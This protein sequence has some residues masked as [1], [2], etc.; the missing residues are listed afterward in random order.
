MLDQHHGEFSTGID[1]A[2]RSRYYI[3]L[4]MGDPGLRRRVGQA[5]RERALME[6][7]PE[8]FRQQVPLCVGAT[9][10]RCPRRKSP[11]VPSPAG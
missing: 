2:E 5:A 6:F 3:H 11:A 10:I 9:I 8:V 1:S 4:V 7:S